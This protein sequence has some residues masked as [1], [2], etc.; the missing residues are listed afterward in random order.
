MESEEKSPLVIK[1]EKL[2]TLGKINLFYIQ[3]KWFIHSHNLYFFFL[4]KG[5]VSP[6][7]ILTFMRKLRSW[8]WLKARS[9]NYI[10]WPNDSIIH[11]SIISKRNWATKTYYFNLK[12]FSALGC[13]EIK[14]L[15]SNNRISL[16]SSGISAVVQT[17]D[18]L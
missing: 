15:C 6:G 7:A 11:I 9:R 2:Q 12:H 1:T 16:T 3:S 13:Y 5:T 8:I 17:E 18:L 4:L 10:L 14:F